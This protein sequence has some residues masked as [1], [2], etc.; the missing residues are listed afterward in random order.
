MSAEQPSTQDCCEQAWGAAR[1]PVL[2]EEC[3][4]LCSPLQGKLKRATR[5][6]LVFHMPCFAVPTA[7][8]KNWLQLKTEPLLRQRER[9]RTQKSHLITRMHVCMYGTK[10][11]HQHLIVSFSI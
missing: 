7:F 4:C 8:P 11:K 2:T 10:F 1:L 3:G 6:P 9:A 5:D